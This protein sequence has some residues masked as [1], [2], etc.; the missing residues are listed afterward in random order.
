MADS[1]LSANGNA[2]ETAGRPRLDFTVGYHA[3]VYLDLLG[4]RARLAELRRL[5]ATEE[6]RVKVGQVLSQTAI[7]VMGIRNAFRKYFEIA[8]TPGPEVVDSIPEDRRD[9]FLR[10]R[11]ITARQ[12]GFSDSFVVSVPLIEQNETALLVAAANLA[13][14]LYAVAGIQLV[15]LANGHPLRGGIEVGTGVEIYG[16]EY[17]GEALANAYRLESEVAQYPRIL[18]G[19]SVADYLHY[20]E[21][22][23]H[24]N[25]AV[26][27]AV[28]RSVAMSRELITLAPDD[29]LPMVDFLGPLMIRMAGPLVA[30][31]G[32]RCAEFVKTQ[33]HRFLAER[34]A[35]LASRYGRLALYLNPSL[36]QR[37]AATVV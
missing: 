30:S 3:V 1:P 35:T 25:A 14:T 23:A 19:A 9:E 33:L 26:G 2:G 7:V 16:Q 31:N 20:L 27:A 34:N 24:Q 13:A 8:A 29:G 22:K 36:A 4:Q 11:T 28:L 17:Y 37:S 18:V 10:L 15:S 21:S 12:H 32:V 6:E 5:P